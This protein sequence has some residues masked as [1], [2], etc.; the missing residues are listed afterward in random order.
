MKQAVMA[1]LSLA[2]ALLLLLAFSWLVGI[3]PDPLGY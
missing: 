1:L 2:G 3:T